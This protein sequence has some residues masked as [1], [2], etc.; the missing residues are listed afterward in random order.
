MQ[1]LNIDQRTQSFHPGFPLV[2]H[3]VVEYKLDLRRA[4]C[5]Q[6]ARFIC[7]SLLRK[8]SVNFTSTAELQTCIPGPSCKGRTK[9]TVIF[10]SPPP[11]PSLSLLFCNLIF[12]IIIITCIGEGEGQRMAYREQ[13]SH[14]FVKGFTPS[15]ILNFWLTSSPLI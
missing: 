3:P 13:I 12:V 6:G 4:S 14:F 5:G 10:F 2:F 1:V 9:D 7:A 15:I 8:N 11:P